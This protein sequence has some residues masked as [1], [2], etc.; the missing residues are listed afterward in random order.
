MIETKS[1]MTLDELVSIVLE[2]ELKDPDPEKSMASMLMADCK[3]DTDD[4]PLK[5][6]VVIM[7]GLAVGPGK[8]IAAMARLLIAKCEPTCAVLALPSY[9]AKLPADQS[10]ATYG[11]KYVTCRNPAGQNTFTGS[12]LTPATPVT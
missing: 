3:F 7:A 9:M 2:H 8:A 11:V 4:K 1:P 10:L 6:P 5:E 12:D